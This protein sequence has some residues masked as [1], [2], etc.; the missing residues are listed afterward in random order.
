MIGGIGMGRGRTRIRKERR[1]RRRGNWG[2]KKRGNRG[3]KKIK[4]KRKR[5]SKKGIGQGIRRIGIAQ[6]KKEIDQRT[7]QKINHSVSKQ[8]KRKGRDQSQRR[9]K[10]RNRRQRKETILP[11]ESDRTL[12][13]RSE[14]TLEGNKGRANSSIGSDL[15]IETV[16]G[17]TDREKT[18][19]NVG[20]NRRNSDS[21]ALLK[22]TRV[23]CRT[24]PRRWISWTRWRHRNSWWHPKP[25]ANFILVT[26]RPILLPTNSCK[27]LTLPSK[28]WRSTA[29][30]RETPLSV[31]GLVPM[32]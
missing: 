4:R 13:I 27:C 29:K 10:D 17:R 8:K 3:G 9:N 12:E 2:N 7:K 32:E 21:T 5:T 19:T 11:A 1:R 28:R 31:L 18:N 26:Y 15:T 25:I 16:E 30:K 20:G 6:K 22:V 24:T 23:I 14:K